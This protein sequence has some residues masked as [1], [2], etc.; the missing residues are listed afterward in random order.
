MD[1][2]ASLAHTHDLRLPDW[3]PY[4]KKYTGISHIPDIHAGLRFDL[5]VF[6]GYY[7]RQVLVPNVVGSGFHPGKLRLI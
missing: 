2:F 4:T 6:P 7:R 3:G 5:S 1:K